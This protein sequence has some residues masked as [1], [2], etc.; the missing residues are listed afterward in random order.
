MRH[1]RGGAGTALQSLRSFRAVP[2]SG[3]GSAST[4]RTDL[5]VYNSL[6]WAAA[7]GVAPDLSLRCA[8]FPAFVPA[9]PLPA[10][11]ASEASFLRLRRILSV[12][13]GCA[14]S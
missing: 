6:R 14:S 8:A 3:P 9:S 10:S 4:K 1:E 13:R 5:F 11:Q 2:A 7:S 12:W